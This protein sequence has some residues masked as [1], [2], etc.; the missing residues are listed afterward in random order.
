MNS[1]KQNKR[2]IDLD[3]DLPVT[4]EDIQAQGHLCAKRACDHSDLAGYLAFLDEIG[5]FSTKKTS[6]KIYQEVFTL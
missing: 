1:P 2:T 5:A 3:K 6:V 4:P